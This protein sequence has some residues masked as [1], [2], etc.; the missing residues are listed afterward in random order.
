[1]LKQIYVGN[2][3]GGG[4]VSLDNNIIIEAPN[5][6]SKFIGQEIIGLLRWAQSRGGYSKEEKGI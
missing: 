4:I 6:F 1:M 2:M 3:D 5:I